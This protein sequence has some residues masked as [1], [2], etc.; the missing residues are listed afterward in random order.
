MQ[1]VFENVLLC[2]RCDHECRFPQEKREVERIQ[3]NLL[4]VEMFLF[5]PLSVQEKDCYRITYPA[6]GPFRNL[7]A[8]VSKHVSKSSTTSNV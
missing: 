5:E 6:I 2:R 7:I 1:D 4:E 3:F 8:I